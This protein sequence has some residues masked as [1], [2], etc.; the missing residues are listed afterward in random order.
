MAGTNGKGS[1]TIKVSTCLQLAGYRTGSF[2][3]PHVNTFRE[4]ILLNGEMVTATEAA[5][6]VGEVFAQVVDSRGIEVSYFEVLFLASLLHFRRQRADFAVLECGLGGLRDATNIIH[7]A[8]AVITSVDLDHTVS[9]CGFNTDAPNRVALG[10]RR[11]CWGTR[12]RRSRWTR[13]GSSRP[14]PPQ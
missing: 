11:K 3:S 10:S 13:P 6:A 9:G 5:D 2:L 1:V 12:W 14:R 4:R 8:L 7:P